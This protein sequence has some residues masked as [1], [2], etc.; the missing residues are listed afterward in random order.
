MKS[1]RLKVLSNSKYAPP[2]V[3]TSYLAHVIALGIKC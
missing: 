2:S 1:Q 3:G